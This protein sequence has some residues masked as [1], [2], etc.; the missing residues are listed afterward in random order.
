VGLVRYRTLQWV[1]RMLAAV[2]IVLMGSIVLI[3]AQLVGYDLPMVNRLIPQGLVGAAFAR[4]VV[5]ISGHAGYDSGAVCTD[6]TGAATLTEAEVNA[7]VAERVAHQLRRAGADVLVVDE[8]DPQLTGL[9]ADVLLSLHAD[10]CIDASGYKAASSPASALHAVETQLL[11]CIDQHY[12]AITGLAHHPNTITHDMLNYHAF[13][14]IDPQTPA[15][16]IELGFLG[17]DQELL[18]QRPEVAARGVVESIL[19]FLTR[20]QPT[21]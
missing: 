1:Q 21:D 20:E 2:S 3:I 8:F 10:S 6:A 15:A 13:R 19:C 11:A 12:P 4:Q 5:L 18:R 7:A 17:G 9:K 14:T 16:I